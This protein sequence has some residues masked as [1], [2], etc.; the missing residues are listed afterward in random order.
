MIAG[1]SPSLLV[2]LVVVLLVSGAVN[3]VA[4]FGFALVGTMALATVIEPATAVVLMII[5]ILSANATLVSELSARELTRCGR[6][7]WPLMLA[8][9]AGTIIGMAVIDR[10]PG[11]PVRVGLGLITLAFVGSRQSTLPLPSLG[12]DSGIDREGTVVMLVVGGGSGLLFGATNVGVQLVAYLRSF[13]LSHGLFVSVVAMVFLGINGV[14]VA[15]AGAL[16][17]YPSAAVVALSVAAVVPS[18]LGV[19]IGRRLR[20]R[21]D[22]RHRAIAV[23]GL[24]SVIGV[25]L[26]LG[27]LG[28]A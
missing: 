3:G 24:L 23:L 6:R 5:P 9:L 12:G 1:F 8:A 15:A 14:R 16:G 28:I 21:V 26:V 22:S 2:I 7:F 17:L 19:A 11:A 25:R 27:G 20:R 4:G 18:V 13:D 10:L